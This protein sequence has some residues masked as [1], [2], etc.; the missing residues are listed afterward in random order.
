MAGGP[1]CVWPIFLEPWTLQRLGLNCV[2]RCWRVLESLP[3]DSS[4]LYAR[5]EKARGEIRAA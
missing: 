3:L 2:W 5:P 1:L 4:I